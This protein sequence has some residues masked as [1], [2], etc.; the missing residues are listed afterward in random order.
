MHRQNCLMCRTQY[1]QQHSFRDWG[2]F[3][4]AP[5]QSINPSYRN[6]IPLQ[7][8]CCLASDLGQKVRMS[9]PPPAARSPPAHLTFCW[10]AK[11]QEPPPQSGHQAFHPSPASG[12]PGRTPT[13]G[14]SGCATDGHIYLLICTAEPMA[15]GRVCVHAHFRATVLSLKLNLKKGYV[16]RGVPAPLPQRNH[17]ISP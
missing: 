5:S 11:H 13:L 17:L 9:P 12:R 6:M 3:D 15:P 2:S 1:T 14:L 7:H 4:T 8:G 10:D 16:L